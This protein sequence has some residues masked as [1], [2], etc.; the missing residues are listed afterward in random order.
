M[1]VSDIARSGMKIVEISECVSVA[2]GNALTLQANPEVEI[3]E[4][5]RLLG[6]MLY[7]H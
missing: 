5:E 7:N 3:V 2:F 4:V 1:L 6:D